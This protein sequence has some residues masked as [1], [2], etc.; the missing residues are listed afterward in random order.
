MAIDRTKFKA[1]VAAKNVEKD[2]QVNAQMGKTFGERADVHKLK[3]GRNMFRIYP[4]HPDKGGDT[5]AEPIVRVFLPVMVQ[6]KDDKGVL[7]TD[8]GQPKMK[9]INK[10][11]FN[12]RIHAGTAKD[13]VEEYVALG[14]VM[15]ES[16]APE[17]KQKFIDK[18]VGKFS[19]NANE[20]LPGAMYKTNYGMYAESIDNGKFVKFGRLEA[21][22]AIKQGLNKAAANEEEGDVIA[23]DPFTDPETGRAVVINYDDKASKPADYY[24]VSLDTFMI[25]EGPQKGMARLFPLSDAQLEAFMAFPALTTLYKNS[26][27]R[28]D[29]EWQLKGLEQFDK[30]YQLGIFSTEEFAEIVLEIDEYYPADDQSGS[31]NGATVQSTQHSVTG[32]AATQEGSGDEVEDDNEPEEADEITDD[33]SLMSRAELKA[34]NKKEGLHIEVKTKWTDD[35]LRS[36]IRRKR[37]ASTLTEEPLPGEDGY[38]EPEVEKTDGTVK[39]SAVDRIKRLRAQK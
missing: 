2:A 36:E 26:F 18:L 29:F 3:P 15:A 19:R 4:P 17:A 33:L 21:G 34:V 28:K 8:N 39:E 20:R 23:V 24:N 35:D 14:K 16:I 31:D 9:E 6:E 27:K 30:K 37:A 7:L 25:K 1:T 5:Y 12:S 38:V 32:T 10:P 11:I 13:L 22:E